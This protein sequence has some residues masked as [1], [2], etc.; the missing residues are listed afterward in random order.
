MIPKGY[1]PMIDVGPLGKTFPKSGLGKNPPEPEVLIK[2]KLP[3]FEKLPSR[4]VP[5]EKF[6]LTH[7]N[8]N[9]SNILFP[10]T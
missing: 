1:P 4:G 6:V 5:L 10:P 7:G 3:Q 8:L 9:G 2:G